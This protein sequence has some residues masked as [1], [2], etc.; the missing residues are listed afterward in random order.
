MTMEERSTRIYRQKQMLSK[1]E[2]TERENLCIHE[3]PA[4]CVAACPLKLDAKALVE[5]V[6]ADG[7]SKA[8]SLYEKITPFVHILSAGCEAPCE[9]KCRLAETGGAIS[10]RSLEQA[11]AAYGESPKGRGL[12][13]FKKKKTAAILGSGLFPAFLAGELAK[14]AY[15]LTVFCAEPDAEAFLAAGA[16]F[17]DGDAV[18]K[19]AGTLKAMDIEFRFRT[20][21]TAGLLDQVRAAYDIVCVSP[22]FLAEA[23]PG[24]A[25]EEATMLCRELNVISAPAGAAGV[26][27]SAFGAKKAALTVDRLAQNLDPMNSRGDEGPCETA[28]ITNMAGAP[29]T[30]RVPGAERGY[31][32]QEAVREAGRCIR[33]SCT[34]CIKGCVYLQHYHKYPK[35]LTREIYN[36]VGI[37]MGDHMMNRP[38]NSCALCG[39]CAVICPNGYDMA[40]ICLMARQNMVT[41]DKMP[42]APHEFA[43]LD[44][45]FSNSD[46][47]LCR[48]Q[49]GFQTCRYVFFP[50]CQAAAIAPET[51]RAA[52]LDLTSRLPGGVALMLG[53]CGAIS[54]W[55]GRY[56]MQE[57]TA[58]F[59]GG[60]LEALGNPTIIAGCPTCGKT[61]ARLEGTK[62]EG[63]WD[64]LD[65]IGLPAGGTGLSRPAALHDACG[66]RGDRRTQEK[67]RKIAEK[68]GCRL[69]ETDYSGDESPCCGYGGLVMYANR[70]VASKMAQ[71]CVNRTDAPYITYC[72]ACRD[73]F[74]REGKASRHILELVYGTDAGAPPDISEKRYNRLSLKSGLLN[75]IWG[76]ETAEMTCEFP[77][78]FTPKALAEMDDRMILKSDVI[79]VMASLR[80]TGEA[81]FD[82]ESGFLVTRKRIGNVTFWVRYEEKDGGYIIRGAYSHRMKVEARQA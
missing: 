11:A 52:Y 69:V 23:L 48:P 25:V 2:L 37:I 33:C 12:L 68:L 41:T 15:P 76:E 70:E 22:E 38:I 77:M 72:M 61:L 58:A 57:E 62:V 75:E 82:S 10:I 17:L 30:A 81:I 18:R 43:L 14:K 3:Q 47:F 66:A 79:A 53:C 5:A 26:L 32:R 45:M 6:A 1:Q 50:G 40:D 60:R 44:Q 67:V 8:L 9:G 73:R 19:D 56:Q 65:E 74:A 34:E 31:T 42:L 63:I 64:V 51:V 29:S 20:G 39:Q 13:R 46:A 78:E 49:P 4:Y 71:M 55:A 16:E 21:M 80:E 54:E 7:F 27:D 59:I 24:A 36:N 35:L 28:L